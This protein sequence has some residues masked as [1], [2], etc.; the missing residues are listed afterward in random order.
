MRIHLFARAVYRTVLGLLPILAALAV[1]EV[2]YGW[3]RNDVLLTVL[4]FWSG[5]VIVATILHLV[6]LSLLAYRRRIHNMVLL[7]LA[8]AAHGLVIW[9]AHLH[10]TESVWILFAGPA[11]LLFCYHLIENDVHANI[12]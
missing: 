5:F 9:L 6:P 4:Q 2:V 3:V 12:L 11:I 7:T 1:N 10:R 8:V